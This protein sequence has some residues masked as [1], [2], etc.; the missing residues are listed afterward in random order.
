MDT[1]N[2]YRDYR[3][4]ITC[5]NSNTPSLK[6]NHDQSNELARNWSTPSLNTTP[7]TVSYTL[8]Q[9]IVLGCGVQGYINTY[10]DGKL[11]TSCGGCG[12]CN[13]TIPKGL[14]EYT[15]E[16]SKFGNVKRSITH[17]C[18]HVFLAEND[19]SG[20]DD[21]MFSRDDLVVPVIWDWAI[22]D[23]ISCEEAERNRSSYPCGTNSYCLQSDNGPGY[24]CKCS[25]GYEGNPYLLDGCQ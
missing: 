25:Y 6:V 18:I 14:K 19:F 20:I 21:L 10:D 15:M 11:I 7:F 5:N 16:T 12:H 1:S 4:K 8:N 23:Y 17:P 2:C 9:F 13:T 3:F 22:T 24:R